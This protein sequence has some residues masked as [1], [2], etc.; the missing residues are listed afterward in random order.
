MGL[1]GTK[2]PEAEA[3]LLMNAY[4]LMFWRNKISKTVILCNCIEYT[5]GACRLGL[6]QNHDNLLCNRTVC[7]YATVFRHCSKWQQCLL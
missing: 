6:K 7:L 5:H 3:Y 1:W 2:Y 4:I